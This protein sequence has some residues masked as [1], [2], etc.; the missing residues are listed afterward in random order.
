VHLKEEEPHELEV[1]KDNGFQAHFKVGIMRTAKKDV[2]SVLIKKYTTICKKNAG[3]KELIPEQ[4]RKI[5]EQAE[6]E[7]PKVRNMY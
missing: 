1:R 5:K 2:V 4:L 3:T 6:S 7:A